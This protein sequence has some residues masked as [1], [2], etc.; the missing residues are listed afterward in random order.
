MRV[1]FILVIATAVLWMRR[2]ASKWTSNLTQLNAL[3][4]YEIGSTQPS[5][6]SRRSVLTSVKTVGNN[7]NPKSAFPLS[8]CEGDCDS[9]ADCDGDLVCFKRDGGEAVPGCSGG[10]EALGPS[11][12][13]ID[14][15]SDKEPSTPSPTQA[16]IDPPPPTAT[17]ESF[18]LKLYWEPGYFWQEERIHRKWC[19]KCRNGCRPGNRVH[20]VDCAKNPTKW[21]FLKLDNDE[22]QVRVKNENLCL[23]R[24]GRRIS[25]RI[26]KHSILRQRWFASDGS[27]APGER[28]EISPRGRP[29]MCITQR[30]HPKHGEE[31][32]LEPTL[33]TRRYSDTSYWNMY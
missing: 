14:T 26:C 10:T 7:G 3:G 27:L 24:E 29:K 8:L 18:R 21:T 19:M 2:P 6:Q 23:E 17:A 25:L 30:H 12:F 16:P 5:Q 9:D 13:C 22:I 28:F 20:I 4:M 31:I 11:D 15:S 33:R 32:Q 1:L